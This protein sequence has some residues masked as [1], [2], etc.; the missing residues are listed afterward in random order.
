ML[1]TVAN[2]IVCMS[3]RRPQ[4]YSRG[5]APS[6]GQHFQQ[7]P[8]VYQASN[9]HNSNFQMPPPQVYNNRPQVGAPGSNNPGNFIH[10]PNPNQRFNTMGMGPPGYA[11]NN[12]NRMQQ[13]SVPFTNEESRQEYYKN[14][15]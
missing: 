9:L 11:Q 3:R 15:K 12:M 6:M 5:N 10:P 7:P 13:P 8:P 1:S 2:G 4:V 14:S